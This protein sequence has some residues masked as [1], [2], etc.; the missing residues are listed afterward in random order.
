MSR[1]WLLSLLCLSVFFLSLVQLTRA[2]GE[3]KVSETNTR[4]L[5]DKRSAKVV[6]AVENSTGETLN[7]NIELEVLDPRD[8]VKLKTSHNQSIGAGSQKLNVS[9]PLYFSNLKED[10]R[11]ELLWYRLRYHIKEGQPAGNTIA[12]GIISFS[13][14]TPD[15]FDLR[16]ATSEVVREKDRLLARVQA[17]HP[18]SR[19][20][21]ANVQIDGE[22]ILDAENDKKITVRSLKTTDSNGHALLEFVIPPLFPQVPYNVRHDDAQ[23]NVLGRKGAIAAV[24]K[25]QVPLDQFAQT[26]VTSDK[27]LY[28]P[29][30]VMH[31]RALLFSPA[32]RALANQDAT[33]RICDPD[34]TTIYRAIAKTSRFGVATTDWSIPENT[35]LGE[36]QI[37]VGLDGGDQSAESGIGVRISRYDLPNFTVNVE[38]DRAYYLPGQNAEVKV[39][40]DYLF[41]KPVARGQVRVVRENERH[42]NYRE[43]KWNV[44]EGDKY[45]GETDAKGVF[46]AQINLASDHEDFDDEYQPYR[47]FTYAAYFTDPTTNRTEQRRFDLR[48]TRE[49]IHVYIMYNGEWV[50]NNSLPLKFYVSTSYADGSPAQVRVNVSVNTDSTEVA[51]PSLATV[52]TNRYGLAKVS[53]VR[54]PSELADESEVDLVVSAVDSKGRKGSKT[55]T[56]SFDDDDEQVVRVETDKAL[57]RSGEP[58]TAFVSSSAREQNVVVDLFRESTLLRSERVKLHR[59]RGSVV[60]AYRPEFKDKLTLTAYGGTTKW[61]ENIG[62]H[63]ILYP[64]D[65][66]LKLDVRP[67]QASYRPGEDAQVNV[68]VQSPEGSLAESAVGVVVLDKAV[69]ERFRTDQEFGSPM[70]TVN[71]SFNRFLGANDYVAGMSIRD[72]QRLDMSKPISADMELAAD[73]LLSRSRRYFRTFHGDNQY[74]R[75]SEAIFGD[76]IKEQLTPVREALESRYARTSEYPTD[77]PGLR[78]LLSESK[79]DLN[80]LR[81]PWGLRYRTW[82]SVFQHSDDVLFESAGADKRFDTA[83]DFVVYRLGWPYFRPTGEA[84]NRAV[85][86]YYDRTGKFVRDSASLRDALSAD[87][88]NVDQLVDRWGKP[89]R[90]E[91]EVNGINYVTKIKSGGS[92]KRFSDDKHYSDDDFVIWTSAIDYFEKTRAQ[93]DET[94][95]RSSDNNTSFPATEK[96]LRAA[97][98]NSQGSLDTLRDPWDRSYYVTF[99]TESIPIDRL[100]VEDRASFREAATLRTSVTPVIQTVRFISLRSAGADAKP[101]TYDDFSVAVFTGVLSEQRGKTEPQRAAPRVVFQGNSGAIQGVITDTNGAVIAGT[102]VKATLLGER[103]IYQTSTNDIGKYSFVNL[104]PGMYEVR[105]EATGFTIHVVTNVL[106]RASHVTDLSVSLRPGAISEVV[107]VTGN[108]ELNLMASASVANTFTLRDT[109]VNLVTKSG[110]SQQLSTPRLRE[111]FPET[112]LWQPSIE[113]DKQGRAQINFK[114]ADNITTWKMV[115]VGSTEDGQIGMAE[116]EIKAF[117]PFFVDHDPPRVLTEGDEISLPV[118][119]RNYLEREQKVDLEIKPENWFSLIGPTR[120]QISVAPSD[121]MRETFD[122]RAIA[123][124]KNGKQRI[125]AIG[126]DENDAIEKPVTVHPDGEEGSVTD[127]DI[128]ADRSALELDIPETMIPN[129]KRGELKIYPNLMTHVVESVEGIMERPYGCGEQTIS[130]TFPSLLLSRYYKQKG[131]SFPLRVRAEQYVKEGYDRLLTYRHESGGFT[132]WGSGEPNLA[133]TAYALRFLT[134][135]SEIISVDPEVI[136]GARV[137]LLSQQRADGSWNSDQNT[138]YV[139]RII[140]KASP[141]SSDALKHAIGYVSEKVSK[142]NDP[143]LLASYALTAIDSRDLSRA[144]PAIDKLR[145]LSR[146]KGTTVYWSAEAGTPFNSW[147]RAGAVETTALVMQALFK[148]C[149]SQTTDCVVDGRLI[150]LGLLFILKAKDRYGVWFS[151]QAT[152]NALDGI[153][154]LLARQSTVQSGSGETHVVVNGRVVQTIQIPIA[155]PLNN[156]ITVDITEFLNAG[157]NRI[158]FRRGAGLPLASVQAVARFYVPWSDSSAKNNGKNGLRLYVKF[159]KTVGRINEEIICNVEAERVGSN[160]T[161]MLLAEIGLPPGADVDRSSLETALQN[162]DWAINRYDVLPD[163]VVVYLWPRTGGVKFNFKFRP[164]LGMNAKTASSTVYDYYNPDSRAVVAPT[165]FKVR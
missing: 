107:T 153:L 145:T 133:L 83:D 81:D 6:L 69:E 94:L 146:V 103:L 18:I 68:R 8:T 67:S 52:R 149:E 9:L 165:T 35:R 44:D 33:F 17:G 156:P 61:R 114:L 161:G 127:G 48:V 128:I 134:T 56:I 22:I 13:E 154:T 126:S 130:S 152:I 24:V 49:P 64:Q 116:K 125:T 91:F 110:S 21:A 150:N 148:Y 32:K 162:S 50:E 66:E 101:E 2:R 14:M 37:W 79:I 123:S 129:S 132:Y 72:L 109:N 80:S 122:L 45:E 95:R 1:R 99:K 25:G 151:T 163:R 7:T 5:F 102:T 98:Q 112:L 104:P 77:E 58:I 16:V 43:Q 59:G 23:L 10:E 19:K 119:V 108:V 82:F 144:K 60:F 147:G 46:V 100:Q 137:W 111:Y 124:I 62:S 142:S 57:Y 120:K 85:S 96:D 15:L 47:D 157:K 75:D 86:K 143:Y 140:A 65:P 38:T 113:T 138:A 3:F 40:A 158:E 31:V 63:T 29:G 117:Q 74:E 11:H 90:F 155:D 160:G 106:V 141:E 121:A 20:P 89:Y 12:A 76:S 34:G 41:G 53:G 88:L 51:K 78:R 55:E 131:G 73:L 36:Y 30:Q 28:Q 4:I 135:A 93:I 92:D 118:T 115:V 42:W 39:R 26:L 71:D 84:I 70:S 136:K 164:R 105:F 54:L 97:L 27:P 159:D 139:S 87:G